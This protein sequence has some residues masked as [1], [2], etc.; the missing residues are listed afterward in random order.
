MYS[1]WVHVFIRNISLSDCLKICNRGFNTLVQLDL[2]WQWTSPEDYH[3]FEKA[4][5]MNALA[6]GFDGLEYFFA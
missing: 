2:G 3:H 5:R 6:R 1:S 4:L